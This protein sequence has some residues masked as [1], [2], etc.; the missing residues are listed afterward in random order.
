MSILCSKHADTNSDL[1]EGAL[2]GWPD[3]DAVELGVERDGNADLCCLCGQVPSI[4]FPAASTPFPAG[5]V[6]AFPMQDDLASTPAHRGA[7][8]GDMFMHVRTVCSHLPC[9]MPGALLCSTMGLNIMQVACMHQVTCDRCGHARRAA[10]CCAATAARPATTCDASARPPR[11][12]PPAT[13]SAPS[14]PWAAAVRSSHSLLLLL[15]PACLGPA[16][17]G[18]KVS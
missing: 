5:A 8:S 12:C 3:Q 13:G 11:A 14:A 7:Q 15:P 17:W 18:S 1:A 4:P 10:A 16:A 2:G 6:F 9:G